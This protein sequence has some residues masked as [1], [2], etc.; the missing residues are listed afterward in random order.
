MRAAAGRD[1]GEAHSR[2]RGQQAHTGKNGLG[3]FKFTAKESSVDPVLSWD[4]T[5]GFE[6]T[7]TVCLKG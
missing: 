2:W 5:K 3:P 6:Q 4:T 1:L 7:D